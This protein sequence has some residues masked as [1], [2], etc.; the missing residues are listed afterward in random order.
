MAESARAI[1]RKRETNINENLDSLMLIKAKGKNNFSTTLDHSRKGKNRS[2]SF[3]NGKNTKDEQNQS[4]FRK[5]FYTKYKI[6]ELLLMNSKNTK[7][8]SKI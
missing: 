1:K 2:S 8:I 3:D 4:G 5:R 6:G 7:K